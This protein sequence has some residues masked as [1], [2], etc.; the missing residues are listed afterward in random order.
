MTTYEPKNKI[1]WY[2]WLK[3]NYNKSNGIWIIIP[4]NYDKLKDID[5]LEIALAF[6]WID[7]TAKKSLDITKKIRYYCPRRK[8]SGW[9]LR[10][11]K[12]IKKL[13]KENK[14]EESGLLKVSEAKKDGSWYKLDDVENLIIPND[15][16]KELVN[17]KLLEKFK[18]LSITNKKMFLLKLINSKRE[19]TRIKII[20]SIILYLFNK[21]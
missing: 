2:N 18:S 11:K 17:V 16:Y 5:I 13:I 6:G 12:L 1:D 21:N 7:S 14:M 8:K 20:E 3:Q 15:L 19:T 4:R 10:N 9:S